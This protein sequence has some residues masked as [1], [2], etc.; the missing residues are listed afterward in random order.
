MFMRR[1]VLK[2]SIKIAQQKKMEQSQVQRI[3]LVR[4]QKFNSIINKTDG[5]QPLNHTA[6]PTPLRP[7]TVFP[8]SPYSSS[9]S[10]NPLHDPSA[11]A[12]YAPLLAQQSEADPSSQ[13][14]YGPR[15]W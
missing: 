7:V 4:F 11:A 6:Y 5:L 12:G 10:T 1:A 8:H 13:Y 2:E 15:K 3:Q 14:G 9:P